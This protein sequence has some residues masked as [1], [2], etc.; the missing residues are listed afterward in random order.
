MTKA[1]SWE[2]RE[3]EREKERGGIQQFYW[4]ILLLQH[5]SFSDTLTTKM[6]TILV[7]KI[8]RHQP[9]IVIDKWSNTDKHDENQFK[10]GPPSAAN[11]FCSPAK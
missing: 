8:T 2:E 3:S 10:C 11:W 4:H 9:L 5:D 7:L 1:E 6:E